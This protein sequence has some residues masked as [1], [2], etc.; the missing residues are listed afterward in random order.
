[1]R[2]LVKSIA[3]I[4][5]SVAYLLVLLLMLY[6]GLIMNEFGLSSN[7]S[8]A[9]FSA[10]IDLI[11]VCL[12]LLGMSIYLSMK[13]TITEMVIVQLMYIPIITYSSTLYGLKSPTL[14]LLVPYLLLFLLCI[15]ISSK[16]RRKINPDNLTD[17]RDK[18]N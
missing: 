9:A 1:V 12:Y 3:T 10:K 15:L 18:E 13:C 17:I 4:F 8:I 14:I 16:L 6:G 7:T 2:F 11:I 5:M